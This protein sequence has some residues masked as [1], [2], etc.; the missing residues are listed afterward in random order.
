MGSS[1]WTAIPSRLLTIILIG[2]MKSTFYFILVCGIGGYVADGFLQAGAPSGF[3]PVWH[4]SQPSQN[5]VPVRDQSET[6]QN[7]FSQPK[8]TQKN[9]G[10]RNTFTRD[11]CH[12]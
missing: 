6:S 12:Y 9:R 10:R 3:V 7:W 1:V 5:S 2:K 4:Q 8:C 11:Q